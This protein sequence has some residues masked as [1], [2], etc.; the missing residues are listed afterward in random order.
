MYL[1]LNWETIYLQNRKNSTEMVYNWLW[2]VQEIVRGKFEIQTR[3][4]FHHK[5]CFT[6]FFLRRVFAKPSKLHADRSIKCDGTNASKYWPSNGGS[7]GPKMQSIWKRSAL[8]TAI[9]PSTPFIPE[10]PSDTHG[11]T[12]GAGYNARRCRK[13]R[14][15]QE[16]SGRCPREDE[17]QSKKEGKRNSR[18]N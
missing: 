14:W 8:Y 17:K 15:P 3:S 6:N 2:G 12:Y 7:S 9:S 13:Y 1:L 5:L 4:S 10:N 18:P 16:S 11:S